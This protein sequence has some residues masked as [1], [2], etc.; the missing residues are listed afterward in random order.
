MT[1]GP[2]VGVDLGAHAVQAV[3]LD[4]R[5]NFADA[6]LFAAGE[7]DDLAV[8]AAHAKVIAI[9]APDRASSGAHAGDERLPPKFQRGRCAEA[10][11]ALVHGYWVPWVTPT[12]PEAGSWIELG[13]SLHSRLRKITGAEV[14]E[15]FPYAAFRHLA[16]GPLPKKTSVAGVRTRVGLLRRAGLDDGCL[17]LWTHDFLDAALAALIALQRSRGEAV[18]VACA[19]DSGCGHDGSAIWLPRPLPESAA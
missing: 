14:I 10:A 4:E 13:I 1:A 19:D 5:G 3:S 6:K 15:V 16:P 17:E 8:W 12:Q 18:R 7:R 9:D 2:F 11:L